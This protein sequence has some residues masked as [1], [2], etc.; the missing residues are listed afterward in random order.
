MSK[1]EIK[2]EDMSK[3]AQSTARGMIEYC[4]E[5]GFRMGMDEGLTKNGRKRAFRRQLEA[6]CGMSDTT[7][8]E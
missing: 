3:D 5:Q 1:P 6:F 4:I 8:G 2:F 7:K